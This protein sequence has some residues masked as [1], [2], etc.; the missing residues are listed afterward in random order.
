MGGLRP[1]SVT[2]PLR[3][4][5]AMAEITITC[6]H[7]GEKA[8]APSDAVGENADCPS[9]GRT[10]LIEA[11]PP[12]AP[13]KRK[14]RVGAPAAAAPTPP[15]AAPSSWAQPPVSHPTEVVITDIRMRF[16]SMVVFMIKWTLA[17][18]PAALILTA[19]AFVV[20]LLM[21]GGCAAMF[22]GR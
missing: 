22:M 1:L 15:P 13:P 8:Q 9:C 6:P 18:I 2:G 12:P 17:S 11:A 20:F 7:C 3:E 14:F 5:H 21:A 4:N 19:I 10:F 16:G